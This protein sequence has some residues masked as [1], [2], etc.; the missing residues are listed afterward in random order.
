MAEILKDFVFTSPTD[1][2]R[3]FPWA[4]WADGKIRELTAGEDFPRKYKLE[5]VQTRAHIYARNHGMKARTQKINNRKI[6]VQFYKPT[7]KRA[8]KAVSKR[9][10][11]R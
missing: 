11:K 5:E 6:V 1:R 4:E 7:T 10:V 8:V 2:R 9:T 3:V